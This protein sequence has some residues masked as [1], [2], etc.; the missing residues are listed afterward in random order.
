MR[1]KCREHEEKSLK[2]RESMKRNAKRDMGLDITRIVAFASVVSV[3]FFLNSGYYDTP[4]LGTRM[5]VMTVIRTFFMVCV[6]LF[7][8]LT[9]YLM[10]DKS[11]ILEKKGGM[12]S[13][14]GKL[15]PILMTY[16]L[17]TLA[18]ILF[19]KV[20]FHEEISIKT[21]LTNV[22]SYSQYSWYVNMYFGLYLMIPFFN[23][24]WNNIGS[25]TGQKILVFVLMV[26]TMLPSLLNVY[27][28]TNLSVFTTPLSY[29]T[30]TQLIPNWWTGVWPITYYFLGAYLRTNVDVKKLKT[31]RLA[32]VLVICVISFGCYNI[33]RSKPGDFIWGV[34]NEWGSWQNVID[35]TLVFLLINSINFP[36][37]ETVIS[38]MAGFL[39][40][41][42]FGAYLFSWIP[43]QVIYEK[44]IQAVS[45]VHLR[46][47]Y[48]PLVVGM[49]III[50]LAGSLFIHLLMECGNALYGK[51]KK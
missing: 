18:I 21:F 42:T 33:W 26:S 3:H 39:S 49:S 38:R 17:V 24:M 4:I 23:I 5:Y 32:L 2:E 51:L 29:T 15:L 20:Y 44:L 34:W 8:L 12:R 6:P 19:K 28:L 50:S 1:M 43:D 30:H 45:N 11:N 36:K 16:V 27:D 37:K 48:A 14:V 40:K 47:N 7:V 13:W 9:G 46:I 22:L 35:S 41:L 10:C 25:K 31:G